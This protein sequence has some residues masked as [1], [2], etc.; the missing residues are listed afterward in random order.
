MSILFNCESNENYD[1]DYNAMYSRENETYRA[2]IETLW[3]KFEAYADTKFTSQIKVAF[4]S[5]YWEMS[6]TCYLEDSFIITS[7]DYGPDITIMQDVDAKIRIE[8]V[9]PNQGQGEDR[10]P[11]II[12]GEGNE[13]PLDKICLRITSAFKEKKDQYERHLRREFIKVNEPYIIAINTAE[14]PYSCEAAYL[15]TAYSL[16]SLWYNFHNDETG[17]NQQEY[18]IKENSA[19]IGTDLLVNPDNKMISAIL[20]SSNYVGSSKSFEEDLILCHNPNAINS[21]PHG[22]IKVNKEYVCEINESSI[23]I[24]NLLL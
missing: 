20:F 2:Y 19:R 24:T 4:Q 22:L 17:Y 15:Q 11:D 9:S 3:E 10:V 18:S 16:G 7:E 1:S 14:I 23:T 5:S 13:V 21:L 8:A 12:I 6:L